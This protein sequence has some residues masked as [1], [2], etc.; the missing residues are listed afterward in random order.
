MSSMSLSIV[1]S[2]KFLFC[3]K[4]PV[5]NGLHHRMTVWILNSDNYIFESF[6]ELSIGLLGSFF[7]LE[8]V[9]FGLTIL[10]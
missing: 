1:V 5:I 3:R 8:R 9:A 2:S 6:S 10:L 7:E 4:Q